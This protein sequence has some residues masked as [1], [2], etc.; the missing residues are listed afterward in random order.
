M[1]QLQ[2]LLFINYRQMHTTNIKSLIILYD[3][4]Q[5]IDSTK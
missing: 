5:F 3:N 2:E 1:V 4:S